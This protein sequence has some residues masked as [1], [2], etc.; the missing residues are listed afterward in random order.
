MDACRFAVEGKHAPREVFI[1]HRVQ[2][3]FQLGSAPTIGQPRRTEQHL[4]LRDGADEEGIGMLVR[5]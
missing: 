3:L 2:L 1:E 4:G 5:A